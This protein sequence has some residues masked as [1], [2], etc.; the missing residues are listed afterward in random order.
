M[1]EPLPAGDARPG[2][3]LREEEIRPADLKARLREYMLRDRDRW[4]A[5]RPGGPGW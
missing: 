1:A 2:K 4:L 3:D 5:G